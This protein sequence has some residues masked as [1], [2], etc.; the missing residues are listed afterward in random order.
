MMNADASNFKKADI[1]LAKNNV[2]KFR[3]RKHIHMGSVILLVVFIYIAFFVYS[4]L[5]STHVS[6]Y[7]V[8]QGTIAVNNTYTG[9]A[10][11][12]EELIPATQTGAINYYVKDA[13]KVGTNDFICSVDTDGSISKQINSANQNGST[14]KGS[15]LS[16]IQEMISEYTM[17]YSSQEFYNIYDFQTDMNAE[18]SEMLSLNALTDI[19]DAISQA[20]SR[21]TFQKVYSPRDG[22]IAY[23]TDGYESVTLENFTADMFSEE[24]YTKNNLKDRQDIQSGDIAYKLIT[25]EEWNVIFPV[26]KDLI[27]QLEDQ[28]TIKIR[29][30]KD[31]SVVRCT[32]DIL[33]REGKSFLVLNLYHSMIRFATDRFLEIEL[34][35]DEK[36][37]LKI[38]NSAITTKEFYTIPMEYFFKGGN[39]DKLGVNVL[40]KEKNN[41]TKGDFVTPIIYFATETSYYVYSDKIQDGDI[42]LKNDSSDTYTVHDT[43]K[44]EGIY[45]IN[46]G[47]TV[48]KQIDVIY[49]NEEYSIIRNNTD[50][51]ISLYDHIALDGNTI[52]E[53]ALINE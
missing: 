4:Y 6:M 16:N 15:D 32:F 48:F 7:E 27:Q 35:F 10:I 51:G 44:L 8:V 25:S 37:G 43:G 29:F 31:S 2:V 21:S 33:E 49:Q 46:K 50:Y 3:L 41:T 38:P 18:L 17:K 9:L 1:I 28:T 5:T 45:C 22:V 30:K 36:R 20:E 14:L 12:Q 13:T 11:R 42:I 26:E 34:L 47:Y 40:R 19:A 52:T 24:N 39:K 53:D 23:Y